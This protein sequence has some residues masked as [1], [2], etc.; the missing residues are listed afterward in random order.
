MNII[1]LITRLTYPSITSKLNLCIF[2]RKLCDEFNKLLRKNENPKCQF[3][4]SGYVSINGGPLHQVS[5]QLFDMTCNTHNKMHR[6][7]DYQVAHNPIFIEYSLKIAKPILVLF[8]Y[9]ASKQ[10]K[11]VLQIVIANQ[12]CFGKLCYFCDYHIRNYTHQQTVNF[13]TFVYCLCSY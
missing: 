11:H 4:H 10:E 12:I 13:F 7:V 1:C 8:C 3:L 9:F 2:F 6:C 5:I